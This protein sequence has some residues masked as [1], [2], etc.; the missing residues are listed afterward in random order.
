MANTKL[1]ARAA[2]IAGRFVQ[3]VVLIDDEA[4]NLLQKSDSGK[5]QKAEIN[6]PI[7]EPNMLPGD[8]SEPPRHREV[9]PREPQ[10][11][12][13]P[14]PEQPADGASHASGSTSVVQTTK[15]LEAVF[16]SGDKAVTAGFENATPE[17]ITQGLNPRRLT[18]NFAR[19]GLVCGV[20]EPD[21]AADDLEALLVAAKRS[22]VLIVDWVFHEDHGQTAQK[23]VKSVLASDTPERLRLIVIYTG[24]PGI[25]KIIEAISTS[26]GRTLTRNGKNVLTNDTTRITV[27]SKIGS[28]K[29]RNSVPLED[30]PQRVLSEFGALYSGLVTMAAMEGLSALRSNTHQLLGRLHGRLD[31]AF[32]THRMLLPHPTDAQEF[33]GDLVGQEI[34]ALLH[35][36]EIGN[37]SGPDAIDAWFEAFGEREP[38]Q[39]AELSKQVSAGDDVRKALVHQ[40]VASFLEQRAEKTKRRELEK[41]IHRTGSKLFL[42]DFKKADAS[43]QEFAHVC[44]MVSRYEGSKPPRLNLGTILLTSEGEYLVCIQPVCD[45]VRLSEARRFAFLMAKKNNSSPNLIIREKEKSLRLKAE[46]KVASLVQHSFSPT[47]SGDVVYAELAGNGELNFRS[48]DAKNFLWKGQLKFAQA[49]RLAQQFSANLARVGLDESEWL[50]RFDREHDSGSGAAE[51][52]AIPDPVVDVAASK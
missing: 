30:L 5:I 40:G 46:S 8:E 15:E 31:T 29:A 16:A 1:Q 12:P 24:D 14:V 34:A 27:L 26:A 52:I 48:A 47:G 50:R 23:I 37:V 20:I 45:C 7:V 11:R 51:D 3:T 2:E 36:H 4:F 21:P 22:D 18:A 35:S 17:E 10:K 9:V 39:A 19:V 43:D 28:A 49:Q 6:Q 25:D 42:D 44:S 41:Q 33:L 13:Q 32:L 38:K